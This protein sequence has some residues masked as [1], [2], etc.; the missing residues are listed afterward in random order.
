MAWKAKENI[1]W[2]KE[3]EIVE[4]IEDNWK[5]YFDEI[6][7]PKPVEDKKVVGDLD[8]DGDFDK[9]DVSLSAKVMRMAR[10]K[11]SK[12]KAKRGKR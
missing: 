8:G 12:K 7:L 2:F 3:G 6:G 4:E 1:L 10:T 11:K 5:P 9:D